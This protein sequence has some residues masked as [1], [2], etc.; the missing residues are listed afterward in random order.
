MYAKIARLHSVA[1]RL[2]GFLSL[3]E[4]NHELREK[5]LS[6][7]LQIIEGASLE[8]EALR[9]LTPDQQT[10]LAGMN[11]HLTPGQRLLI[12]APSG[13]GK[14]TWL[15]TL[16][17]IWPFIDGQIR[18]PRH[19][20]RLVLT[21]KAYFPI[22]TLRAALAYPLTSE[23]FTDQDMVAALAS[24]KLNSLI[25]HLDD[26][27]NWSQRLSSGEQQR[28][29]LARAFLQ[30][31]EVLFLDEATSALEKDTEAEIYQALTAVFPQMILISFSHESGPLAVFHQKTLAL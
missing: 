14:T 15:R 21:Q 13:K 19:S 28:L 3:L 5:N 18:L 4:E 25:K 8:S 29:A 30:K 10:L 12:T 22:G 17:G 26:E 9:V 24:T 23:L 27:D 6:H 1:L 11:L 20:H 7:R 16:N 2:G 31:P